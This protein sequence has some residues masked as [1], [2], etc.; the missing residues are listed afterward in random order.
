ME[1]DLGRHLEPHFDPALKGVVAGAFADGGGLGQTKGSGLRDPPVE[2]GLGDE[3]L[4][5]DRSGEDA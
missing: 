3:C 1:V 5:V 4:A 2:A